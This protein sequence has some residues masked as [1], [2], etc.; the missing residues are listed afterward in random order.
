MC[1]DDSN[2]DLLGP[3]RPAIASQ[4]P[5]PTVVG[6]V[7]GNGECNDDGL[8]IKNGVAETNNQCEERGFSKTRSVQNQL[9]EIFREMTPHDERLW[10]VEER[11]NLT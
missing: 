8:G 2:S 7:R 4:T 11:L 3:G 9:Q 10:R 5:A 6:N 1:R